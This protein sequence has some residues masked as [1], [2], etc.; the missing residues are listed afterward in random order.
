MRALFC[1]HVS[2]VL[3]WWFIPCLTKIAAD[4]VD[5]DDDD[6]CGVELMGFVCRRW[7]CWPLVFDDVSRLTTNVV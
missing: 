6:G 7:L 3:R 2:H 5:D 4:D 1:T